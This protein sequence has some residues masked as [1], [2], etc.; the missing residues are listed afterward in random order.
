LALTLSVGFLLHSPVK[1]RHW[2][3]NPGEIGIIAAGMTLSVAVGLLI[4][5]NINIIR[6]DIFSKQGQI[7]EERGK[8]DGA[9]FFYDKAIKIEKNQDYYYMSL[10]QACLGKG[11]SI[12]GQSRDI[13]FREAEKAL[14]KAMKISP[15]D[16]VHS[17]NLARL[18]TTWGE[19]S[20]GTQRSEL[21]E[22]ALTQYAAA[23]KLSPNNAQVYNEWGKTFLVLGNTEKANEM[24]QKSL[25][26]DSRYQRTYIF[27]GQL[28]IAQKK[29]AEAAEAFQQS[30]KFYPKRVDGYIGAGYVHVQMGELEAARQSYQ[31]ALKVSPKDFRPHMHLAIL[32]QKMGNTAEAVSELKKALALAPDENKP[33]LQTFLDKLR[34]LQ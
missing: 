16:P 14:F 5:G 21:L 13:W 30:L 1:L 15:L 12:A 9:I 26:L 29:W 33:A 8:W 10:A 2:T 23:G 18:Y 27:L 3:F 22:K 24:Y 6:A 25:S 31:K 20:K 7:F 34:T 17:T 19:V 32:Y 4:V 28:Y 11:K